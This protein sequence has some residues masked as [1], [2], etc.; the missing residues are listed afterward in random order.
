MRK[1]INLVLVSILLSLSVLACLSSQTPNNYRQNL[2]AYV[3]QT[4][5]I[6][7]LQDSILY[8]TNTKLSLC[9]EQKNECIAVNNNLVQALLYMCFIILFFASLILFLLLWDDFLNLFACISKIKNIWG[10]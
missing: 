2:E 3:L 6:Q 10:N 1:K 7:N 4:K 5:K 9:L 8:Y